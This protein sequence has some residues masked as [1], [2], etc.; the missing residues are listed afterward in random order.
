MITHLSSPSPI[1]DLNQSRDENRTSFS[2]AIKIPVKNNLVD[3]IASG[4][5][6]LLSQSRRKNEPSS[7]RWKINYPWHFFALPLA[8]Q[9][10]P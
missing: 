7:A 4:V 1:E 10:K 3:E 2:W 8:R 5:H 9:Q 6:E